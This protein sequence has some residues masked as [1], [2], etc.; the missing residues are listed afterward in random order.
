[1][2]AALKNVITDRRFRNSIERHDS[3]MG[4]KMA[5]PFTAH[6][7]KCK[8]VY[9][10]HPID[11]T[12]QAA[13]ARFAVDGF[14]TYWSARNQELA[15]AM[16]AK[17]KAMEAAGTSIWDGDHVFTRDA[18]LEFP[19]IEDVFR[20]GLAD[21][22]ESIY[23]SHLKVFYGKLYKAV[24]TSDRPEGSQLWHS[25]GGPGTCINVMFYL[26]E[27]T[28]SNGA[29]EVVSWKDSKKIF[30]DE[31]PALRKLLATRAPQDGSKMARL[32]AR[33]I[34]TE[35]YREQIAARRVSVEQPTGEAGLVLAFRN[36]T[37]HKGGF[38]DPERVRYVI[39]FHVYPSTSPLAYDTYRRLG[40]AKTG[41]L[42][43]DPA[44]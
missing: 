19:E 6:H 16:L 4:V 18:W 9:T 2:L 17:I 5:S 31:R 33:E 11:P 23:G 22:I 13:A 36:N 24:R 8:A 29:M 41:A 42:P 34:L 44:F 30:A 26:S 3:R 27:G 32:K 43:A 1:M 39:V 7:Q 25:D 28:S 35:W 37:I 20:A 14:A 40:A 15:Q 10:T 12:L 38:P 21:F